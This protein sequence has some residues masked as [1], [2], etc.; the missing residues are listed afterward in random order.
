MSKDILDTRNLEKRLQELSDE[1]ENWKSNLTDEQIHKLAETLQ[2]EIIDLTDEDFREEW[3]YES[4]DNEMLK[5]IQELKDE[6][7][8]AQWKNGIQLI[9]DGY[10]EQFAKDDADSMG[11]FAGVSSSDW[12]FSYIDW[13]R[14]AREL[15]S[16]YRQV[17][18]DGETYWYRS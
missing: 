14:A 16:D 1:Y 9:R 4:G 8:S 10:F 3:Y 6:F 12:P 18:F 17:N 13:R 2:C 7:D 15:R 11:Y 5:Y